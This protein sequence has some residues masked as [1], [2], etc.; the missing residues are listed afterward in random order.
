MTNCNSFN[1][2]KSKIEKLVEEHPLQ[3][4]SWEATRRC[5]LNCKH[6][7]SPQE[8]VY[9]KRE[10]NTN[11]TINFF[12]QIAKDFDLSKFRHINITGG[13]PFIRKDLVYI[14]KNISQNSHYQNID[15][16][17][18]GIILGQNPELIDEIKNY[19]V[20]GIGVSIDG[21]KEFHDNFR[22]KNGS[23][24]L[25]VKAAQES[26][27]KGLTTTISLVANSKNIENIPDFYE[28]VKNEIRP[29][30]FRIM[31]IDP[32][33]RANQNEDYSLSSE[34]TKEVINFLQEK[35]S[36]TFQ[37][38]ANSKS[39]MVE[40]GCGGWCGR[41]LEATFRPFIFHCVA[42]IN[43]LGILYDG[44]IAA[45]SNIP[46]EFGFE[47]DLRAGD[48]IKDIWENKYQKYRNFDWKKTGECKTCEEWN[49]C[50]GGP[51]HKM[52]SDRTRTNC[53]YQ[54]LNN[55]GGK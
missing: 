49:Y 14:L 51:M 42:G 35:Y 25:S 38:Y 17:T 54:T 9:A 27:K 48:K 20:T 8:E 55:S 34:Q 37:D 3:I 6:C 11:E 43:N 47:G 28:F 24:D 32:L 31:T 44:K 53:L 2:W 52:K 36:E 10:L 39:M 5:N 22:G 18:N 29:R 16:Q 13:E 4:I 15:I 23:F 12:E 41:D 33:G 40:L 19:G 1:T 46:R 30:T 26:V 50:H 7:G 21:F 45:C